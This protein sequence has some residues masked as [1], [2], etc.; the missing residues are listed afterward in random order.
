MRAVLGDAHAAG[1]EEPQTRVRGAFLVDLDVRVTVDERGTLG[2]RGCVVDAV[3]HASAKDVAVRQEQFTAGLVEQR[4]V[5]GHDG[6]V[7]DHLVD[8]GVAVAAHRD[9]AI[10]QG[11]EQRNHA[12][13]GVVARQVV[14]RAVVEQVAQQHNAVGLLGFDSGAEALGPVCRAVDVGSDEVFHGESFRS[15]V[16]G[17]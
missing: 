4:G 3:V 1:V 17:S 5:V 15:G 12:L 6:E 10:S 16:D 9:N 13:G 14:T 2:Q 8:L 7:E 11:V